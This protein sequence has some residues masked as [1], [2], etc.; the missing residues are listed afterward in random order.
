MPLPP[1]LQKIV[2]FVRKGYPQG[3][4]Q[5]DYLPLLA[6]L[7]RRLTDQEVA[8]L[9]D[10]L[11]LVGTG[12]Q[13]SAAIAEAIRNATHEPPSDADIERVRTLLKDAGWDP[14]SAS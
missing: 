13:A 5:H 6:L 4:P 10:D 2:D 7:R 8:S 11:V 14:L 3:V 1:M 9:A 12:E